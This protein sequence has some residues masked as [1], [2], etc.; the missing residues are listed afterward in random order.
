MFKLRYL[1]KVFFLLQKG[2][3]KNLKKVFDKVYDSE[4]GMLIEME[5]A[6]KKTGNGLIDCDNNGDHR[7]NGDKV[8]KQEAMESEPAT[9]SKPKKNGDAA[10]PDN[11]KSDKSDNPKPE[12][13]KSAKPKG[14][15]SAKPKESKSTKPEDSKPEE[16]CEVCTFI[17]I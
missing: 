15:K 6:S 2:Y 7:K 17:E 3:F 10:K 12:D 9:E 8:S 14:S 5:G 1:E 13:S 4:N 11:S 16:D